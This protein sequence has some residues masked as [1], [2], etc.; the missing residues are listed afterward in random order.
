MPMCCQSISDVSKTDLAVGPQN[1]VRRQPRIVQLAYGGSCVHLVVGTS[2]GIDL[3]GGAAGRARSD[4]ERVRSG[5]TWALEDRQYRGGS[6]DQRRIDVSRTTSNLQFDIEV[7]QV[8]QIGLFHVGQQLGVHG[9]ISTIGCVRR[10]HRWEDSG[11]AL[12]VVQGQPNL[13]EIVL[14]LRS[15][16]CFAGLLNCRQEQ[17]NQDCNDGDDDQQLNQCEAAILSIMGYSHR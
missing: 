12:V 5:V 4:L 9:K 17:R 2:V 1:S 3:A 6:S 7:D 13:L 11:C 15:S 10:V 14:A 8:M 16:S